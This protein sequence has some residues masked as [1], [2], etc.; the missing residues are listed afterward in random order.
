[1]N[2]AFAK[3][4]EFVNKTLNPTEMEKNLAEA[5]SNEN[6]GVSNTIKMASKFRGTPVLA[7]KVEAHAR[8]FAARPAATFSL[9]S[10]PPCPSLRVDDLTNN[11]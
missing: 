3:A 10:S 8:V 11:Q 5:L 6:W 9:L 4:A 7:K 1:M 2:L